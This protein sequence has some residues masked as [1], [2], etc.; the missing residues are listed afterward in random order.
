MVTRREARE[1]AVQ[2][3]FQLDVNDV[4]KDTHAEAFERF[5]SGEYWKLNKAAVGTKAEQ[6]AEAL[7]AKKPDKR[8]RAFTEELVLGVRS[9]LAEIDKLLAGLATNWNI[10]RMGV[11]DRNVLRLSIF[12]MLHRP[13]IPPAVS[14]NEA[15]DLA[16]YFSS[17]ESGRFVN[18]IL[19][20][21]KV[22]IGKLRKG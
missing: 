8:A 15:I 13:D 19:D 6:E 21:A 17:E 22:E 9:N 16:K 11:V 20:K 12:E 18:G 5:W 3:L 2:L 10:R 1:W 14:I 7:K 4:Q